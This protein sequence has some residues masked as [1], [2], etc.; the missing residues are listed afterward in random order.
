MAH[1]SLTSLMITLLQLLYQAQ[2]FKIEK[3]IS[4][5]I[6]PRCGSTIQNKVS[7]MFREGFKGWYI[8]SPQKKP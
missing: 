8:H 4:K 5:R 1:K 7:Y 6:T 3:K 2:I